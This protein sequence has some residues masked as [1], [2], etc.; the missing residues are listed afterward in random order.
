MFPEFQMK[1]LD[2]LIEH[3]TLTSARML[4]LD[5]T[6]RPGGIWTTLERMEQKGWVSSAKVKNPR[7]RGPAPRE[8]TITADGRRVM[9]AYGLL[10]R[11]DR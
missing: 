11:G 8:F 2:L 6:M 7:Q 1:I 3:G 10:A 4:E 9:A 5:K